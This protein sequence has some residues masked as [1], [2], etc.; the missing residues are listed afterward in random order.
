MNIQDG[1]TS[2]LISAVKYVSMSNADKRLFISVL[3]E[4]EK[5]KFK[6]Q[7]AAEWNTL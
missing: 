6:K 4:S 1:R 5:K 2:Q 7:L 3:S